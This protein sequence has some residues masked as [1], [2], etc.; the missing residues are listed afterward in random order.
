MAAPVKRF[1]GDRA[2]RSSSE[3]DHM[4]TA[5]RVRGSRVESTVNYVRNPPGEGASA[6][7][8]V[9]EDESR[10]TMRDAAGAEGLGHRR[11]A[12][13]HRPR[14]RGLRPRATRELG[15]RL[16]CHRGGRR[17]RPAYIDGDDRAPAGGDR[18]V[19][20]VHARWGQEAP[21]RDARSRSWRH[22]PTPSRPGTRTPTT[23][24]P[25][26][27]GWSRWSPATVPDLD[28]GS[29]LAVGALQ[30]VALRL[31]SASGRALRRVRRT[32]RRPLPTRSRW[33]R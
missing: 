17:G 33:S 12:T 1:P 19:G 27:S 8:F 22:S 20:R 25:P 6:L 16:R 10:S 3:G 26:Q 11:A 7:E 24:T 31:A 15:G 14:P 23:P 4:S 30:H 18:R 9:T 2:C 5:T 13:V 28:L 32:V 29:L 21:R